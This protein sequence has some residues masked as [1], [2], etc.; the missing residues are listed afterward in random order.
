MKSYA[1]KLVYTQKN[2]SML[3][4]FQEIKRQTGYSVVW[5]E[6][7]LDANKRM[8]VEFNNQPLKKVLDDVLGKLSLGYTIVNKTIII[9]EQETAY[10]KSFNGYEVRG[11]IVN[12][13]TE[14]IP[15]A[16]IKVKGT[17]QET[18][19]NERGEFL[20]RLLEKDVILTVSHIGYKKKEIKA[21][22]DVGTIELLYSVDELKEVL[23]LQNGYQYIPKERAAGSFMVVDSLQFNRRVS[24]DALLR[25]EGI[26]GG[27]L[28]NKNTQR[29]FLGSMDFSIRGRS[30]IYA[31]D[32]PLVILDNFPFTGDLNLINP[33]DIATVTLLK[34]ATAA[35]IWGVRAGNGVIVIT[36]KKGKYNQGFK[37][38]VN[39]NL[40]VS[41]K[42]NLFYNQNYLSS[43]DYIDMETLL[44]NNGKYDAVL[45]DKVRYPVVSPAVQILDRQRNGQSAEVTA[46]QLN[47]LR[48]NDIRNEELKYLYRNRIAE[49]YFLNVSKG[50]AKANHYFSAGY[51]KELASFVRNEGN[52]FTLNT[53][54][55][56]K[57]LDKLELSAELNYVNNKSKSD[58]ALFNTLLN[59]PN[60]VPYYQYKDVNGNPA[61]FERQFRAPYNSIAVENGFLDWSYV[62]LNEL[63]L[64]PQTFNGN[65]LR[66]HTALKYTLFPGLNAVLRYQY[67]HNKT[68]GELIRGVESFYARDMINRYAIVTA[69]KVT[70][71]NIPVGA[72][73]T[74]SLAKSDYQN[75]RGQLNYEKGI[76]KHAFSALAGYELSEF[77]SHAS[78]YNRYGY[79]VKTGKSLDVDT[80][81]TFNLNPSGSGKISSG[82]NLFGKLDRIRSFFANA[83]YTYNH[84]YTVTASARTDGSNYFGIKT[85]QK[86]VPLWS[87]GG[88]WHIDGEEFYKLQWLPDLKLRLSYGFNGNLDKSSTGITTA[89][90]V[91]R[92]LYTNLPYSTILNIG[93]P[94]LRWEKIRMTNWALDFGLR[95]QII[96]GTIEY[97]YKKGLDLLGD[98]SFPSSSG[99]AVLRGNYS[100]MKSTG[101]DISLNIRNLQR[102]VKWNT[103]VMVS[104]MRDE[105]TRYDVFDPNSTLYVG[106]FNT[107]PLEG[108]PV[109]G[110]FS[111]RWEGLDPL[112]GDPRGYLNGEISKDYIRIMR[113]TLPKDLVYHGPARPTFFGSVNN[114]IAYDRF[115][116]GINVSFKMGYY[117]R[118]PS[119]N[120]YEMFNGTLSS[121]V[122]TDFSARWQNSGDEKHT[123]VPSMVNFADSSR[124]MFYSSSSVTVLKGD[125]IRL[126]DI[127]LSYD[128]HTS[129]WKNTSIKQ[130][131]LYLYANNLGLLWKANN[132]DLDPDFTDIVR[133]R[134]IYPF[135]KSL[136]FG[137]KAGF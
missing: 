82:T 92:S 89:V 35:S 55:S 33:N 40:T 21:S 137:L 98:K 80:G 1:Q 83:A 87:A 46:E 126:Q 108:K 120:Y 64:P 56:V 25:L 7:K 30:T 5:N 18:A 85:N 75:Y 60:Y 105:V 119:V 96:T 124:D 23:I 3:Q 63:N 43:T 41:A 61:V 101:F 123:N 36:S 28:F 8:N 91:A 32:Q 68:E 94:E 70:G 20:L 53:Q 134:P 13:S 15:G 88:L 127:S 48:G 42:P 26:A 54:H 86:N 62:P 72:L 103:N 81:S 45:L 107:Q 116:M 57:L 93:N 44:F 73:Q 100:E 16:V 106:S 58:S 132:A 69:G 2:T 84:R 38:D 113:E 104:S 135:P 74:V 17:A 99:V 110:V 31:N 122:H 109:Y 10:V 131:Q 117:F 29:I 66:V 9:K 114:T 6:Q 39:S 50:S 133:I 49:Q 78:R 130:I 27:L 111:Y 79:D 71:Y 12:D 112:N 37:I 97:F 67:Q 14:P 115:K 95:N 24:G 125:H 128:L 76:G 121:A 102:V 51:D 4:L 19:T 129:K 77:D 59:S 65:D 52:R 22:E 118:K 90:L 136:S 47:A 34:D 11:L